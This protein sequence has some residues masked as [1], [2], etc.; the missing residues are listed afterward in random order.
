[1]GVAAT[2]AFA[3]EIALQKKEIFLHSGNDLISKI[4]EERPQLPSDPIFLFPV[5]FSGRSAQEK[6]D[7]LRTMIAQEGCDYLLL[8]ALDEI[9]WTFNIRGN[10]VKYNP[11]A[12]SYALI[13]KDQ[14]ILFLSPAKIN[15]EDLPYFREEQ[16]QL[17]EYNKITNFLS[18]LPAG[19]KIMLDASKTNLALHNSIP[20]ACEIANQVSPANRLKSI[21]NEVESEGYKQA[22]VY[23]GVALT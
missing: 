10:D 12:I 15:K 1:M 7:Q 22:L 4:W 16:I 9:A 2:D 19:S 23:H 17:A 8:S 20:A 6:I 13:S 14:S 5:E 11:V 18:R 3:L 21:K